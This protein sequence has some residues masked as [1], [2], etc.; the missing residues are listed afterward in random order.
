VYGIWRIS[1]LEIFRWY[2][3]GTEFR[4]SDGTRDIDL[5]VTGI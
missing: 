2:L 3:Y 1:I 4:R 5:R